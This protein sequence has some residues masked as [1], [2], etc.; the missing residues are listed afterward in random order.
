MIDFGRDCNIPLTCC[1]SITINFR[2]NLVRIL[3][4]LGLDN[5]IFI[6]DCWSL[7]LC[8]QII[9]IARTIARSGRGL[10]FGSLESPLGSLELGD[11]SEDGGDEDEDQDEEDGDGDELPGEE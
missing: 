4:I 7:L 8:I 6:C 5:Q 9:V 10:Q 2:V 3:C 11:E 1:L